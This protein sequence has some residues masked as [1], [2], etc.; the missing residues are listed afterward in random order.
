LTWLIYQE[1]IL[2]ESILS[3]HGFKMQN[4]LELIWLIWTLV[5][6]VQFK[7]GDGFIKLFI[8]IKKYTRQVKA[9]L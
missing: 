3:Q 4:V 7:M 9:L 5:N 8:R 6:C 2:K 1:L